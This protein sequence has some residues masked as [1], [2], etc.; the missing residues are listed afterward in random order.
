M[1]TKAARGKAPAQPPG[2]ASPAARDEAW[3]AGSQLQSNLYERLP[4]AAVASTFV[5]VVLFASTNPRGGPWGFGTLPWL[6]APRGARPDARGPRFVPPSQRKRAEVELRRRLE[7]GG[8]GP[9]APAAPAPAG[10]R[11]AWIDASGPRLGD[12]DGGAAPRSPEA[13]AEAAGEYVGCFSSEAWFTGRRYLGGSRG[14]YYRLAAADALRGRKPYFACARHG[15]DGHGFVF[16]AL[17]ED[18]RLA[19]P[20][21]DLVAGGCEHAC[22]DDASKLCGCT[23]DGCTGAQ[24]AGQEHHRRWAVYRLPEAAAPPP[25]PP[26]RRAADGGGD[27]D[28]WTLRRERAAEARLFEAAA[29][30]AFGHLGFPDPQ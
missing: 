22:A 3:A 16:D 8:A 24:T 11:G 2:L 12:G 21:G 1:N 30:T 9:A 5:C 14:A 26:E 29:A 28:A 4:R 6:G 15:G 27:G 10:E 13:A 19:F 23:D 25:P 7:A 20:E 18:A 17:A